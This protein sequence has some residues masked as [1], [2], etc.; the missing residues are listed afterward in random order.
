MY[1]AVQAGAASEGVVSNVKCEKKHLLGDNRRPGDVYWC[2][3]CQPHAV[4]VRVVNGSM[5]FKILVTINDPNSHIIG[6]EQTKMDCYHYD[7]TEHGTLFSPFALHARN[8][9]RVVLMIT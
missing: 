8:E 9:T 1:M 4:D 7:C 6:A 5:P 3:R 2:L